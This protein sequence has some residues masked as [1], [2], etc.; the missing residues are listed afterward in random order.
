ML[1]GIWI[2]LVDLNDDNIDIV[3]AAGKQ[4]G[5]GNDGFGGF[6]LITNK[7]LASKRTKNFLINFW[8]LQFLSTYLDFPYFYTDK[9]LMRWQ[10]GFE[11]FALHER[12][13]QYSLKRILFEG[14]HMPVYVYANM[15]T[16]K[17]VRE[18][19]K[20]LVICF[21]LLLNFISGAIYFVCSK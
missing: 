16:S 21:L 20:I 15:P 13:Q 11:L 8:F 4:M 9:L 3:D 5:A 1:D 17:Y 18:V 6:V 19:I 14:A 10:V 12:Q 2:T 7:W